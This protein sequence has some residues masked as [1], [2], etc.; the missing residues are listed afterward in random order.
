MYKK[1][2]KIR[3]NKASISPDLYKKLSQNGFI[4]SEEKNEELITIYRNKNNFLT[5][6]PSLHIIVIT[7][8]C[9]HKCIYCHASRK[10]EYE[11]KDN[12]GGNIA[13]IIEMG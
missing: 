10:N 11:Y 6:G 5:Q 8:R 3:E 2:I 9:D 1:P 4:F 13:L 12:S 7:L